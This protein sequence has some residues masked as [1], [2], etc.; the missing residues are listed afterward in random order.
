MPAALL[1]DVGVSASGMMH[2][3]HSANIYSSG[4]VSTAHNAM[5]ARFRQNGGMTD[6]WKNHIAA[7]RKAAGLT[8]DELAAAMDPPSSKGMISQYESG[9]RRPRQS[10]LEAIA[11]AL[12]RTPGE[13]IDGSQDGGP[14]LSA[15]DLE[16]MIALAM[17]ELPVGA[18]N[19]DYQRVVASSLHA[20]LEQLKA[21]GGFRSSQGEPTVPDKAAQSRAP[22]KKGERAGSR[23]P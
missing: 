9:K 23:N 19:E 17:R 21:A 18:T 20:Q 3:L 2:C 12:G 11:K 5:A 14:T 13:L 10:T 7:C 4:N 15:A 1:S 6:R 8:M 22:T 16:E